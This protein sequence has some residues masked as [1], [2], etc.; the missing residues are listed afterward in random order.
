MSGVLAWL[1]SACVV[2]S[3][4]YAAGAVL[5]T[6]DQGGSDLSSSRFAT[7]FTSGGGT[8]AREALGPSSG[9]PN[10][11][12]P[13]PVSRGGDKELRYFEDLNIDVAATSGWA[14]T[15]ARPENI[16]ENAT[17][18][19]YIGAFG[20]LDAGFV[21]N[22]AG[23]VPGAVGDTRGYLAGFRVLTD[24]SIAYLGFGRLEHGVTTEISTVAGNRIS[25]PFPIDLEHEN[26]HLSFTA[27]GGELTA[28]LWRVM[29]VGGAV[30]EEP[31]DLLA[32]AGVQNTMSA[33]DG[34]LMWNPDFDP[35]DPDTFLIPDPTYEVFADGRAGLR[36]FARNGDEVYF[37]D[38]SIATVPEPTSAVLLLSALLV[39]GA[40]ARPRVSERCEQPD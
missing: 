28:S 15:P 22:F 2:W 31:I 17:I 25:Q 8:F 10:T 34:R 7:V 5:E 18:D 23:T 24:P 9:A 33:T 27:N 4:Q 13:L 30:V 6:F 36:A 12:P 14:V 1:G 40:W 38:V 19:G 11:A 26:Y 29:V 39:G 20:D 35:S 37:D 21:L 32:A 16:L 3:S